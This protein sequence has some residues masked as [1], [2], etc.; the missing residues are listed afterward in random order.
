LTCEQDRPALR[1]EFVA[2]LFALAIAEVAVQVAN[3]VTQGSL[4]ARFLP[5]YTHLI[6]ATAIVAT[7]WVGWSTSNAPGAK[8]ALDRVFSY[9]FVVLSV[10][11]L[12]VVFYFIIARGVD[13]SF[14]GTNLRPQP[15][16]ANETLWVMLIFVIYFAWDLLTKI[17]MT[18]EGTQIRSVRRRLL[19]PTLGGR[20]FRTAACLGGAFVVW[21]VLRRSTDVATVVL[22]DGS[23]VA[24]VFLFRALKQPHIGWSWTL[25]I[26]FVLFTGL[27]CARSRI[28]AAISIQES[29]SNGS[30]IGRVDSLLP[31]P[32]KLRVAPGS[33]SSHPARQPQPLAPH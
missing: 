7:S 24:L 8:R 22:T 17:V 19:D 1:T 31:S 33:T 23:L 26:A 4:E 15:S 28:T 3:V 13:I 32:A 21:L 25:G 9:A 2:M 16:A 30:A 12:L 10:D 14:E 5:A 18:P 27:A 29:L 6:L 11:V 20:A